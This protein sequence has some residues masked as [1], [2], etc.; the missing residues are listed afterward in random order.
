MHEGI[1]HFGFELFEQLEQLERHLKK[2]AIHFPYL[3]AIPATVD[4]PA[5]RADNGEA[6]NVVLTFVG[7]CAPCITPANLFSFAKQ[8]QEAF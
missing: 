2:F 4:A 7:I 1:Q 3:H 5:E 6:H 8:K